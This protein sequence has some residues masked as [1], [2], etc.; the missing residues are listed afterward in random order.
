[1][2][3][4]ADIVQHSFQ[5]NCE[6]SGPGKGFRKL[7]EGEL[8]QLNEELH[9][10]SDDATKISSEEIEFKKGRTNNNHCFSSN[11]SILILEYSVCYF[12]KDVQFQI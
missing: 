1:M 12:E 6:G 5:A 11:T 8:K 4:A 2:G 9:Q 3:D 7:R 10:F